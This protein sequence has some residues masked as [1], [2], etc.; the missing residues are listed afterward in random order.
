MHIGRTHNFTLQWFFKL[1]EAEALLQ[2]HPCFFSHIVKQRILPLY[3]ATVT[4]DHLPKMCRAVFLRC[5]RDPIRVPRIENRVPRIR[6][7]YH[8][9][10]RIRE[11]RVPRIREI[12]SL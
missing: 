12:G 7:S 8:R 2:I 11:N 9:V 3:A 5:F 6:E 4:L 10:R 1:V